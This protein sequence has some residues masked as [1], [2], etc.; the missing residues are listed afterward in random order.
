MENRFEVFG[1]QLGHS[2]DVMAFDFD[3]GTATH[4]ALGTLLG[5]YYTGLGSGIEAN[6]APGD[7]G[8]RR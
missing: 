8:D 6:I 4:D 1:T 2:P 7:S 5:I 3:D